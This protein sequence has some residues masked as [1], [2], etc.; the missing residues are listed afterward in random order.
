MFIVSK[1]RW[2]QAPAERHESFFASATTKP[3][4]P[5]PP[6][7]INSSPAKSSSPNRSADYPHG[8][9]PGRIAPPNNTPANE[10]RFPHRTA[11][12]ADAARSPAP[13]QSP[14]HKVAP[15]ARAAISSRPCQSIRVS[16]AAQKHRSFSEIARPETTAKAPES[17]APGKRAQDQA[18]SSGSAARK[19][20]QS[21]TR[22]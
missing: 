4:Q 17:F 1:P 2:I 8:K 15:H 13:A 20:P 16:N 19:Y 18:R 6:A 7:A 3:L 11:A 12:C 21:S 9:I 5:P 14:P 22:P 10:S